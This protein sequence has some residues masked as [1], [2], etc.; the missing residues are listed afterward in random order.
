MMKKLSAALL[1]LLVILN[2]AAALC[3]KPAPFSLNEIFHWGMSETEILTALGNVKTETEKEQKLTYLEADDVPFAFEALPC[4]ITFGLSA[5]GLVLMML[6]FSERIDAQD[7]LDA[8]TK[9]YG[10]GERATDPAAWADLEAMSDSDEVELRDDDPQTFD[11][12]SLEDGT[13]ALLITDVQ[14]RE[15]NLIF[16]LLKAE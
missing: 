10:S 2:S 4:E 11:Q 8:L 5:D 7:V 9:L 14:D 13:R 16:Y 3:E 12:W 1:A 6:D 15:A